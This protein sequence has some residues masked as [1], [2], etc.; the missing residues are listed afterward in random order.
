MKVD[1][2]VVNQN[3]CFNSIQC[4]MTFNQKII[5]K[6]GRIE[7]DGDNQF[8][9][10]T[11]DSVIDFSI[12]NMNESNLIMDF[13][14]RHFYCL[15]HVVGCTGKY[16]EKNF[17]FLNIVFFYNLQRF[18]KTPVIINDEIIETLIKKNYI[19]Q[20]ENLKEYLKVYRVQAKK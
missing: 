11:K 15:A 7:M 13:F 17:F 3:S 18:G 5:A 4:R 10:I 6:D 12:V 1:E 20:K 8:K 14:N 19:K 2:L 16:E 9:F